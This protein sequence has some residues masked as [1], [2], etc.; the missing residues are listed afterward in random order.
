MENKS[1]KDIGN[2]GEDFATRYLEEKGYEIIKRN[3]RAGR[4]EIDI[5]VAKDDTLVFVEA[6][7]QMHGDFGNPIEWVTK[8]KQRQIGKVAQAYLLSANPQY[9]NFRFDVIALMWDKGTWK[10]QHIENAFWL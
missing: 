10:V 1:T 2:T 3:Y 9:L 8:G 4:G 6:K 7:T 5:I